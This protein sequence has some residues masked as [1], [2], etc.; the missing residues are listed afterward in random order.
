MIEL[1]TL[2]ALDLR[3]ADGRELHALL[4][5][6]KRLALL[7]Y[8]AL[9]RGQRLHRRDAVVALFWPDL[10][11]EHARGALRQALRFLRRMLG[12]GV[13]VTRGEEEVGVDREMLWVD[14]AAFDEAFQAGRLDDALALYRGDFLHGLFVSDTGPELERQIDDERMRFRTMAREAA[15]GLAAA[16]RTGGDSVA[17]AELAR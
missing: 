16:R 12:D 4:S 1:R 10:D 3:S 11:Q 17:G 8:L 6:P 9:A 7:A 14:A 5:Q 13:I 15:W 2:G